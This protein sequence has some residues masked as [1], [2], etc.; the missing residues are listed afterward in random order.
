MVTEGMD[1]V[2]V[3]VGDFGTHGYFGGGFES[4]FEV[5]GKD[6]LE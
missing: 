5:L 1:V 4:E 6:S 3:C 2:D